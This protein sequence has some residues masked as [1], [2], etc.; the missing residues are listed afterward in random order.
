MTLIH[1]VDG[2]ITTIYAGDLK[3]KMWKF[4]YD[5]GAASKFVGTAMFAATDSGGTAQPITAS[6]VVFNHA[7]GGKIVIFGTGKLFA[8][9]DASDTQ[10]QTTYA[11]WDKTA[12]MAFSRPMSRSNLTGRTLTAFR[13]T[14]SASATTFV[15][16]TDVAAIDWTVSRGWRIDLDVTVPGDPST[17]PPT[18]A[19]VLR[20]RVIYP[21]LVAGF[22]TAVVSTVAPAQ[23]VLG[24]CD[25]LSGTALNMLLPVQSG[26]N[27][28]TKTFDTNGSGSASSADSYAVGYSTAADGVDVVVRSKNTDGTDGINDPGG[29][30][31]E[32]DCTG[33]KCS[34]GGECISSPECPEAGTCLA[35]IQSATAGMTVCIPSGA[36]ATRKMDRVWRRIINPP[37]K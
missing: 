14:G 2:K 25:S 8:D 9:A 19:T 26:L 23:G 20:P 3:G 22:D 24:V 13:G 32:G 5:P 31:H 27:P 16:L 33:A 37:I 35:T 6:P 36:A 28:T 29:G 15:S 21:T 30:G 34:G 11:V 1:D 7:Q 4:D 10:V 12:D 17:I 18:P